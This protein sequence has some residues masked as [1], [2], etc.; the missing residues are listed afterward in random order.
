MLIGIGGKIGAGKDF[1][2]KYLCEN[3]TEYNFK[4]RSFAYKVKQIAALLSGMSMDDALSHDGKNK[5]VEHFNMTLGRMQQV[6]GTD[7][8]RDHFDVDTWVKALFA[9]YREGMDWIVTDV[10]FP[11]EAEQIRMM[12]GILIRLDGDPAGIREKSTRDMSHPSETS[13]DDYGHFTMIYKTTPDLFRN[14]TVL[15]PA[16]RAALHYRKLHGTAPMGTTEF[17]E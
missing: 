8:F 16:V 10:R 9:D 6:I 2:A 3:L 17:Y 14:D 5:M 13:L 12:G 1:T 7:L 15:L 11:N 4:T